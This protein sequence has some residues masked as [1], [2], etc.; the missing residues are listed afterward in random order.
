[1]QPWLVAALAV[2][3][4]MHVQLWSQ[5]THAHAGMKW[6]L[7]AVWR[8]GRKGWAQQLSWSIMLVLQ[9]PGCT[10]PDYWGNTLCTTR[11]KMQAH[12]SV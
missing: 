9:G 11:C 8:R 1:M 3:L 10:L 5:G 6:W 7:P 2:I 12:H 4:A